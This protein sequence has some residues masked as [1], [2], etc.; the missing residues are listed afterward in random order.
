MSVKNL[1]PGRINVESN[2]NVSL[3]TVSN[4]V[5]GAPGGRYPIRMAAF[6]MDPYRIGL[7]WPRPVPD[8]DLRVVSLV[9]GSGEVLADRPDPGVTDTD[10]FVRWYADDENYSVTDLRWESGQGTSNYFETAVGSEPT[11]ITD[12]EYKV[13]DEVFIREA[14]MFD[15]DTGDYLK[16]NLNEL[17]GSAGYSVILV[18]S[19]TSV[20]PEYSGLWCPTAK[21]NGWVSVEFQGTGIYVETEQTPRRRIL[22]VANLLDTDAPLML[23]MCFG[24]PYTSFYAAAGPS[25]IL[26]GRIE[27]GQLPTAFNSDIYLGRSTEDLDHALDMALFDVGFYTKKLSGTEVGDEFSTLSSLYGGNR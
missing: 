25:S 18:A 14:L 17:S 22:Q 6:H 19:I 23:A 24:R 27:T 8:C 2:T 11:Y 1:R 13:D 21:N 12:Y 16:G 3:H 7:G 15:S 10:A 26:S 20:N 9:S 5:E 4:D